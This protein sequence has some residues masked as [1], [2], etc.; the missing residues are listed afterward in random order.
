M[1]NKKL[2][3]IVNIII[4]ILIFCLIG[5]IIYNM[6]LLINRNYYFIDLFKNSIKVGLIFEEERYIIL[7]INI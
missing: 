2:N 7:N 3:K 5:L 1:D 4:Y 6:F